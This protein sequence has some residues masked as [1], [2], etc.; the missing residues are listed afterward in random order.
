MTKALISVS[1]KT[2]L[3]ELATAFIENN[4]EILSTGGTAAYLRQ[5]HIPL[6]EVSHYTQFPEIMGGRVKTLH[7]KIH[8]GILARL[9]EDETI[10]QE[11][12]IAAIDYVI[13]NLYPFKE[14]IA[15]KDC[16]QQQAIENIDIGGPT[17][18]RAAAKNHQRVSVLVDP[19]DYPIL[20]TACKEK[21]PLSIETRWQLAAKAFSHTAQ[22]DSMIAAYFSKQENSDTLLPQ[23]FTLVLQQ[24]Q[25]LRY[26]ENSHQ[27]AG[28]YVD[29]TT[30]KQGTLA[31]SDL[32]QG[33]A[34]SYN[35]LA[36]SDAAWSC[37][38]SLGIDKKSCVIVKHANPC[39]V[40]NGKTLLDAYQKAYACDPVSA[41]GGVIAFNDTVEETLAQTIIEQQ[42]VEVIL[43]PSFTD[44]AKIILQKKPNVRCLQVALVDDRP[45]YELKAISGGYLVQ[46]TDS[47]LY[48]EED[49]K[50]VTTLSP[51]ETQ[52]QDLKFAWRVAKYVKS[53]AIVYAAH[54]QTLGIG[55]G[56]MSRV[57]SARIA[58]IKAKEATLSLDNAVMASDAF[59]PFSD[60]IENAHAAGIRAII[61]PGGS[62]RDAEII[63]RANELKMTMVFTNMRHF[64]H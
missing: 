28:L 39:G 9:P 11:K 40:A 36:D 18:V 53:N 42:F 12:S 45:S 5:H 47:L 13:V 64:K 62:I 58:V 16:S 34:L 4:I 3:L 33:K 6:E 35:N 63:N 60:S 46:T 14:T 1:D 30:I 24:K 31:N 8:G 29:P 17:L 21:N 38:L 10:M 44:N 32:L 55:A 41:F 37:L 26:G 57:D 19:T 2:G 61:Q 23:P 49:L 43:A 59:F 54:E 52:W 51:N 25:A 15:N 7:P 56:Q 20:I 48:T 27:A 50:I 22:Y